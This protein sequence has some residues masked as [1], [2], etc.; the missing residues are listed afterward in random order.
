[1]EIGFAYKVGVYFSIICSVNEGYL[2][3]TQFRALQ[4]FTSAA[5]SVLST[6]V[7]IRYPQWIVLISLFA[8][9]YIF[10]F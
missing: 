4:H 7:S 3:Y 6:Q 9:I 2:R 8:V 1:M 10:I 5:L